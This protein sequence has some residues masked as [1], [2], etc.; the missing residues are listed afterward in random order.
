LVGLSACTLL[1]D[2]QAQQV[3]P[4]ADPH[5]DEG[6][7]AGNRTSTCEWNT[8]A[9]N[10]S[11]GVTFGV[12]VRPDQQITE[13]NLKPGAETSNTT[14]TAGRQ[15]VLVKNNGAGISCFAAI[16]V[17]SGR[18]DINATTLRGATT[19]QMCAIVSKIDDYVEPRLPPS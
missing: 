11:G 16:A 19:E 14:S 13:V 1:T 4:G 18:V 8:H 7:L 17:G 12:T 6:E 10:D 9:T 3:A 2:A 5:Q 15:V